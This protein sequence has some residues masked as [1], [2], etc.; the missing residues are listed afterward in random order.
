M[1][2]T[3]VKL[4]FM[5]GIDVSNEDKILN[6]PVKIKLKEFIRDI[7]D[8]I[9]RRPIYK[10][11]YKKFFKSQKYKI[12]LV[13]PSKGFSVFERKK[14]LNSFSKIYGKDILL[15]GCGNGY[16]VFDWIKFKPRSITGID[17][18][19]YKK[20]WKK[21]KLYVKEK[22]INTKVNFIND[23]IIKLK[24]SNKFD[25]IVSDAVFEHLKNFSKVIKKCKTLLVQNGMIYASYGPLWYTLGGDHFSNRCNN[26]DGYNHLL[27]PRKKYNEF[28]KK[29]V[30]NLNSEIKF[31]GSAGIFVKENLFS[32]LTG[33]Q[34][35]EI[36][37]KN[38]FYSKY[39]VLEYCPIAHNLLRKNKNLALRLLKKYNFKSLENFYL[40]TKIV[41][42]KKM[43]E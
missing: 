22:K 38:K 41:Y 11:K 30:Q 26:L 31:H 36:L 24:N 42:L 29:N 2:S 19:N 5:P 14:K 9:F 21:I 43:A 15:L 35:I 3:K 18:L 37:K 13:L 32:K 28:F 12:N 39:T 10:I 7:F 17:I 20:S 25:F 27:L 16:D 1:K 33:N 6:K 40:K 34:Y 8:N 4:N 23:D